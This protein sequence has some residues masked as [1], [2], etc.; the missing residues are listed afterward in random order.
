MQEGRS[1]KTAIEV[2]T[3]GFSLLFQGIPVSPGSQLDERIDTSELIVGIGKSFDGAVDG[4]DDVGIL[5]KRGLPVLHDGGDGE[6]VVSEFP[7]VSDFET[8]LVC[9]LLTDNH[10]T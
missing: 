8:G 10:V 9:K 3:Y 1:I 6:R 5:E 4:K 2:F 7:I